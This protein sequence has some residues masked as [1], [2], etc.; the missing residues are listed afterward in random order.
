MPGLQPDPLEARTRVVTNDDFLLDQL[1]R[2]QLERTRRR[3]RH[4]SRRRRWFVL[5]TATMLL[6]LVAGLPSLISHSPVAGSLLHRAAAQHGLNAR[7]E[8]VQ[9]GWITPLTIRGL[10]I[11]GTR[12]D[13]EIKIAEMAADIT[14]GDLIAG[15]PAAFEHL[16][17]RGVR[18][19]CQ[20]RDGRF[21]L[22]D[23]FEPLLRGPSA[24]PVALQ[25]IQL[26]DV[27]LEVADSAT[28]QLWRGSKI[29]ADV[30][31]TGGD[32][33][34][35]L[36]GVFSESGGDAGSLQGQIRLP[37]EITAGW[38]VELQCEALPL[39]VATL[40]GKRLPGAT[41]SVLKEVHGDASG[42]VV[43]RGRD[44]G[45]IEA[46]LREL[47]VRNLAAADPADPR[48]LRWHNE[49]ATLDGELVLASGTVM[50]R[51]LNA[52]AD[53]GRV[54]LDGS[55]TAPKTWASLIDH[56][57]RWLESLEGSAAAELDLAGLEEALP[58]VIPLRDEARLLSGNVRARLEAFEQQSVRRGRV[59]LHSDAIRGR[60]RGRPVVIEPIDFEATVRG[61]DG[62]ITAEQFS[63]ESSFASAVGRGNLRDGTAD[64]EIHFG[65][66]ASMLRPLVDLAES[67]LEGSVRGNV[68]WTVAS[69]RRWTLAGSGTASELLISLPGGESVRRPELNVKV[70]AVGRWGEQSLEKLSSANLRLTGTGL[71]LR[72][73][74]A[75]P[76]RT[77]SAKAGLPLR[78]RGDGRLEE[79]LVTIRPWLPENLDQLGGGFSLTA[80]AGV[81]ANSGRLTALNGEFTDPWAEY[82]NRRFEQPNLKVHFDGDYA[83][84][85]GDAEIRSLTL[86]GDAVSVAV[87]GEVRP[88][89]TDLQI[90]W[91]AKLQRLQGS[92]RSRLVTGDGGRTAVIRTASHG[93]DPAIPA[94]RWYFLGDCE[95]DLT[96]RHRKGGSWIIDSS[97]TGQDFAILQP[98]GAAERQVVGPP[99]RPDRRSAVAGRESGGNG[100][101]ATG[102]SADP[103]DAS[104]VV[105][106]EPNLKFDAAVRHDPATGTTEAEDLQ[107]S[108]DWFA[109]TLQ[110]NGTW[111]KNRGEVQLDGPA[112]F[113]MNEV[114][115]RLTSLAGIPIDAEGI[116]ETDLKLQASRASD[117]SVRMDIG[118]ELGWESAGLAGLRF[119]PASVPLRMTETSVHVAS[120][121]IPIGDGR[122]RIGGDVY[123]RPGPL[124]IHA[125]P[126][127]IAESVRLTPEMTRRWLKYIA[128]LAANATRIDGTLSATLDEAI[129][130]IDEPERSRVRG[131]LDIQGVTMKAGPLTD[132][133]ITGVEQ[134]M[135]LRNLNAPPPYGQDASTLVTMPPQ[136]V[137]FSLANNV[138]RH[139]RLKLQIDRADV[140][141]SGD[142]SLDGTLN[143]FAQVPLD[144]AW[145][146]R[147]LQ[148]LAGQAVTLPVTGTLSQPKLDPSAL[149]DVAGQIGTR[150]VEGAAEN[151]L[152]QQIERGQRQLNRTIERGI[153]SLSI[154]KIFGN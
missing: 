137:D 94:D 89:R 52:A 143:L 91:R 40:V 3:R 54:S 8:S 48:G 15:S 87:Q 78:L 76:V 148:H 57:A 6:L 1:E 84:P 21:T 39:A 53:F 49:S 14:A 134:L 33:E 37:R 51:G 126:G 110:G 38:E 152:R 81:A 88:A 25:R 109:T 45:G 79:L 77:P 133:I 136:S 12:A 67:R 95:G 20:L 69:D 72:A 96:V 120:S 75:R 26:Q 13:S 121:V 73:E 34:A 42:G 106:A 147:D 85:G 55:F 17:L 153:E 23:D 24:Q 105:W 83:W 66:L 112:R 64:L 47:R 154:E 44:D 56:P 28:G 139:R 2:T 11:R 86:A 103:G 61:D 31:L 32:L 104:R 27:S 62:R 131:R 138:V 71:D 111:S 132:R 46:S 63:W 22:E 130:V 93:G 68:S 50:G 10:T 124:W 141:T 113:K 102:R 41:P 60:S 116:H 43:V 80:E 74:L 5:G 65:R 135:T 117:G 122:L 16:S 114:A 19:K 29:A 108:G 97:A 59:S 128:P 30:S 125:Q 150:A 142:V 101:N 151:F 7:A 118:G 99:R 127:V 149:R 98:A 115:T 123:Y 70:D 90:A 140:V 107:L 58:G 144:A 145:L 35:T 9:V 36:A 100:R 18:L 146:G 129:V 92:M 119:G 82:G 4:Q